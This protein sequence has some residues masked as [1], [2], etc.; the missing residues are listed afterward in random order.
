MNEKT[1]L[2]IKVAVLVFVVGVLIVKFVG[3]VADGPSSIP[4]GTMPLPSVS[5]ALQNSNTAPS[6]PTT[7]PDARKKTLQESVDSNQASSGGENREEPAASAT[8][9][10]PAWI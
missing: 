5:E 10:K 6:A 4:S 7:L 9:K 2:L 3:P 1:R 8:L